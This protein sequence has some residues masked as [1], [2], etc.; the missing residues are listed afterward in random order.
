MNSCESTTPQD[1]PTFKVA[2]LYRAHGL[3]SRETFIAFQKIFEEIVNNVIHNCP[4]EDKLWK[5][6]RTL[7][8]FDDYADTVP[9]NAANLSITFD[10]AQRLMNAM[11]LDW[12][13]DISIQK[14]IQPYVYTIQAARELIA[15]QLNVDPK[16]IAFMRNGSDP[17]AVINNG[18]DFEPGDE[19]LVWNENHPTNGDVAWK[20]RKERFPNI[21]IVVLDLEGETNEEKIIE[22]FL[23]KVNE[24]T[25]I[26]TFSE[27]SHL[28]GMRLP[29]KSLIARIHEQ[30]KD[31]HVHLDGAQSWGAF[32]HDLKS[33]DCD[34]YCGGSHK[35]FLGPKETGILYMKTKS[36]PKFWP[37]DIGY[38]GEMQPPPTLPGDK[39]PVDASRF[40]MVGQRNDTNLMGLLYTADL[41]D[42][43]GF[44]KIER[45]IKA[46]TM[47]LR[48]G[49]EDMAPEVGNVFEIE[50]P[51]ELSQ[52]HG[53]LTIKFVGEV[54]SKLNEFV[55]NKLYQD[56][57][58]GVSTKKENRMRF[59]PHIYNTE[60]HIDRAV[61]AIKYELTKIHRN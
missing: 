59:S 61:K 39:L 15:K 29:A 35:W 27:V 11:A 16:L 12:N 26:V 40:E 58:I 2:F 38:N 4:D 50:T 22:R 31:V 6:V 44:E 47:R 37:K 14:R 8:D 60:E 19:V 53:I 52:Y 7:F 13:R 9:I 48:D 33:I 46:L 20:I 55:Y 42:L 43:I 56:H 36:V 28:S 17:N 25:R 30:N 18:M 45:R 32:K 54:S 51:E 41:M 34:S 5:F 1:R 24:H 21:N 49:L 57:K 10:A 3:I 23:A